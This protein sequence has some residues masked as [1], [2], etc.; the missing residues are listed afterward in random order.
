MHGPFSERHLMKNS[1]EKL[2]LFREPNR[3]SLEWVSLVNG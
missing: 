1:Y 2:D 3:N